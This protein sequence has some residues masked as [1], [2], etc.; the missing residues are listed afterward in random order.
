L[1]KPDIRYCLKVFVDYRNIFFLIFT[2][3]FDPF[4][5]DKAAHG[6]AS[7]PKFIEFGSKS[8]TLESPKL[9]SIS[10]MVVT[11]SPTF[12]WE[13]VNNVNGYTIYIF[14]N[15]GDLEKNIFNS[16]YYG[17]ITSNYYKMPDNILKKGKSYKIRMRS[18]NAEGWSDYSNPL[19]F[20]VE[21]LNQIRDKETVLPAP[22][23]ITRNSLII[24]SLKNGVPKY[25]LVWNNEP[26]VTHYQIVIDGINTS[27]IFGDE[28]SN[29]ITST[30][31]DT[32]F[33]LSPEILSK[34]NK[35]RWRIRGKSQY[36][37][38]RFSPYYYFNLENHNSDESMIIDN[39][40]D[41]IMRLKYAG[42]IDEMIIA[43]FIGEKA[44]LPLI[45][46]LSLLQLNHSVDL[47]NS[48]VTGQKIDNPKLKYLL[49]FNDGVL[50]IGKDT[51]KINPENLIESDLEYFVSENIVEKISGMKVDVDMRN[52]TVTLT[53]DFTLPIFQRML[54]EQKVSLLKSSSVNNN[55]PLMFNRERNYLSGGFFDYS[56]TTNYAKNQLPYY[57]L[58][59]GLGAEIFGGDTRISSQQTLFDKKIT[60]SQFL[61]KWRYAILNNEII[62]NISLG[63]NN[64]LGLQSYD[65]RGIQVSNKP[66]ESRRIYGSYNIEETTKPNWKVEVFRNSQLVDIVYADENG[67]YN[68]LLPFNYGTTLLEFHELGPNGEYRIQRKMYQI[69]IDQVPKGRL[70]YSVNFGKLANTNEYLLHSNADYGINKWLSTKV[71]TDIFTDNLQQS[72]IYSSTTARLFD[73][74]IINLKMAPNAYHEL[75]FNTIFSHLASF[76]LGAKLHE[77]NNKI[78]PTDIK[79][80]LEGNVF[81]PIKINDNMMSLLLRGR[82]AE[83][84]NSK[85]SDFSL[86]AFY[87]YNNVSPSIEFDYYNLNN[88]VSN[89]RS[90]FINFR[91][92]YSLAISSAI[93]SGN[94]IDARYVYDIFNKK[95]QSINVSISSTLFQ[96]LRVQLSH[97]NNFSNS[98]SDTQLRVV[99]DLPFL[100]SS[101]SIS[102]NVVT[103]SFIGSVNYNQHLENFNFYNRGMIG[104]SAATFKFFVD[105]NFNKKYDDGENLVEDM[106]IQI[107]SIGNKRRANEGNVIVNDLESYSKYEVNLI[108]RHNKNPLWFPYNNK[109]SFISDPH[110][111]KEIEIPFYEAAEVSGQILKKSKNN[112]IPQAGVEIVFEH[113]ETKNITKIKTM[114]DGSFYYYGMQP[115]KYKV[116]PNEEN[117]DVLK[118]NSEPKII[119]ALI[120]SIGEDEKNTEFNFVLQ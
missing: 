92:N 89:F 101:S 17:P 49:K 36:G 29:I 18:F 99:F 51:S 57:S 119:N 85:R 87:N 70:D 25:S 120:E 102:K 65:F 33:N 74:Y 90:A 64:I 16:S 8:V 72:S 98:Y 63:D 67:K 73:S 14:E 112:I 22:T 46:I 40:E 3:L 27:A 94:I 96:Q 100:R 11:E 9:I 95:P 48:T 44:L 108:D 32:I 117:L 78:N 68:F 19:F 39:A 4:K 77:E 47:E 114:S 115:G 1:K 80:E 66:L 52:L 109:F 82:H 58:N 53:S 38:S 28:Y 30:A 110:Q 21:L 62:S 113:I 5:I 93:F 24:D 116:Y 59:F 31:N 104:R 76:H 103:Q 12:R 35:Y 69:P 106:D 2:L 13:H 50:E 107:N 84:S 23:I 55:Y 37:W 56:A 79:S 34:F 105:K 111:Y 75:T 83:Y 61:Y 118:L 26:L 45:E 42:I 81:L 97:T 91:I 10:E 7:F 71:G 6:F 60:S 41:I 20:R 43:Q 54:N 15:N 88:D 86:R